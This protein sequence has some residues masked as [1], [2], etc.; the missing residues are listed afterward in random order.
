MAGRESGLLEPVPFIHKL[1][2]P[3]PEEVQKEN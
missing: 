2:G 3:L 1:E